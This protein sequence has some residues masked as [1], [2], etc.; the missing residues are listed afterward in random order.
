LV[1]ATG[2]G[3]SVSELIVVLAIIGILASIALPVW[4]KIVTSFR[5]SS[6]ARL[7]HS[8]L[9][10]LKIRS[11]VENASFRLAYAAGATTIEIQRN[12][13]TLAI[14]PL[15]VGVSIAKA[16]TVTF[17]P[18]GTANGNRVRLVSRDGACQQVVV[19]Q[20]GRTRTCKA[21]CGEEC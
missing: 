19:S 4:N 11:A 20:T 2:R 9:Q 10:N 12:G 16:G 14:K 7:V 21:A 18:R 17:S 8:E 15:A 13:K 3:F 1:T 5:L 6:S